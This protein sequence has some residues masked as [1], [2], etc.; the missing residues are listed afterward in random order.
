MKFKQVW[1][2]L[3][4]IGFILF[5]VGIAL[6]TTFSFQELVEV[7]TDDPQLFHMAPT[8][9]KWL[10]TSQNPTAT[11]IGAILVIAGVVCWIGAVANFAYGE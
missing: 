6:I 11:S 10:W 7:P 8:Q 5:G 9:Q 1:K 4:L 2:L 3:L